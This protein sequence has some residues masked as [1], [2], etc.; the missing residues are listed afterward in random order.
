MVDPAGAG[1]P[2]QWSAAPQYGWDPGQFP[3]RPDPGGYPAPD[4]YQQSPGYPLPG[5]Q[6]PAYQ[7][8]AYQ[9]PGYQTP[10]Y[11]PTSA[12]YPQSWAPTGYPPPAGWPASPKQPAIR[13][14]I[15]IVI[16]TGVGLLAA[17]VSPFL[18]LWTFKTSGETTMNIT[19]WAT[20]SG[21]DDSGGSGHDTRYGIVLLIGAAI[22][23][24]ALVV[25]LVRRSSVVG[26][27][28]AGLGGMYLVGVSV[29]ALVDYSSRISYDSGSDV[30]WGA[31]PALSLMIASGAIGLA[32][33]VLATVAAA[34][35]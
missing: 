21:G 8:P 23:L 18:T 27:L 3:T 14:W 33:A 5:Y 12:T 10:G 7:T 26:A 6:T 31:G 17:G 30:E 32:A 24:A 34:R 35:K 25:L 1:D 9:T 16:L 20:T 11:A 22:L 2:Q 15:A 19:G 28:L 13:A 29:E 4:P